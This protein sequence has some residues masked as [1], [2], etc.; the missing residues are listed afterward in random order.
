MT[1]IKLAIALSTVLT[2]LT[3]NATEITNLRAGKLSEAEI[4]ATETSLTI[5]GQM[6]AADFAYIFDNLNAL[7]TLNIADV[8][9]VA[10]SGSSLPYTGLQSSPAATLPD[11]ALTGLINLKTL[12]LPESLKAIGKGSLSG[13]GITELNVPTSVTSIGDY[14]AMRCENLTT[15]TVPQSVKSIGTRAF[16]YCPKLKSVSISAQITSIPEGL[17]EACGGLRTLSLDG[18]T[19]CSEIGAWMVA[20]CDGLR[21]LVLPENSQV[22]A[23]GAAYAVSGLTTLTLPQG[24]SYIADN[25]MS[26]MSG[27]T[28]INASSLTDVPELGSDVWSRLDQSKI[29]LITPNNMT[30]EFRAAEQ[31]NQFNIM[32]AE[33]WENSTETIASTIDGADFKVSVGN[34]KIVLTSSAPMGRIAVFN[35]AG[36]RIVS[37][38]AANNAEISVSGWASGVYLVATEVGAAKVRI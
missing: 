1:K 35:V 2:A 29:T 14:A 17:F 33:N 25:A 16:A 13:S 10:Y 5:S 20:D 27:L 26:A 38:Q 32:S 4:E 6:N 36:Q 19:S 37:A 31:W 3:A 30:D 23:K 24:L 34:G 11:Y 15:I 8:E 22:I 7:K 12:V 18:L 21:T 28:S 9:I